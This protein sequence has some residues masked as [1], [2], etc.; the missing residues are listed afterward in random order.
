[1]PDRPASCTLTMSRL[2]LLRSKP[3]TMSLFRFSS[4]SQR[5]IGPSAAHAPFCRRLSVAPPEVLFH[6]RRVPKTVADQVVN[7]SQR[8]GRVLVGDFFR[9][10]AL[11]EGPQDRVERHARAAYA[12]HTVGSGNHGNRPDYFALGHLPKVDNIRRGATCPRRG[13]ARTSASA[14]LGAPATR[15]L[16][17]IL[18]NIR[19]PPPNAPP[20]AHPR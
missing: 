9:C 13:R 17:A 7:V 8:N 2:G 3:R 11:V 20:L 15:L 1:M 10:C 19:V 6:L 14:P 18:K 5:T 12:D 4:A 16:H